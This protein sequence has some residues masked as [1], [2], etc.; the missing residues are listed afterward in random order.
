[1]EIA[2]SLLVF[3]LGIVIGLIVSKI[4]KPMKLGTLVV[5]H[6]DPDEPYLFLEIKDSSDWEKNISNE[7]KVLFDV[8]IRNYISHK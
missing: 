1:M 2:L 6:S 3:A 8:E 4:T 5:D 7:K